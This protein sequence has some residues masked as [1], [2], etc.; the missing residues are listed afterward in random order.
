MFIIGHTVDRTGFR[1]GIGVL[2]GLGEGEVT[3]GDR[4]HILIHGTAHNSSLRSSIIGRDINRVLPLFRTFQSFRYSQDLLN[5]EFGRGG[6]HTI[7]VGEGQRLILGGGS[8]CRQGA[9]AVVLN[10]DGHGLAGC[11]RIIGHALDR[12][13]LGHGVGVGAGFGEGEVTEGDRGI[14]LVNRA[15]HRLSFRSTVL[16]FHIDGVRPFLRAFKSFRNFQDLLDREAGRSRFHA[17]G[18]GEGQRIFLGGGN[19][20]RQG[21]V[22]VVNDFDGHGLAGCLCIV[23]HALDRAG[24]GHGVGVGAGFGEGEVAEGDRG[25][26]LVNRAG[27][28]LSFRRI[29]LCFHIDGV[30]PFLRAVQA[31]RNFQDLLDREAGRGGFHTVGVGEGQRFILGGGN[32]RRQGAV[33]VVNHRDGHGLAVSFFVVGHAGDR[34]LFTYRVG[35]GAGSGEGERTEGDG[36]VILVYR[37]GH[38]FSLRGGAV[39]GHS[40]IVGPLIRTFQAFRNNQD[41]LYREAGADCTDIIGVGEGKRTIVRGA[42]RRRQGAVAVV[43]HCDR[44]GLARSVRIIGHTGDGSGLRHR[45]GVGSGFGKGEIAEGDGIRRIGDRSG[46]GRSFRRIVF[47]F[48]I[49]RVAPGRRASQ[50]CRNFKDLLHREAGRSRFDAVGVC[51]AY[52][53]FR[54]YRRN[55][56]ALAIVFNR[57]R[58]SLGG[59]CIIRY[60]VRAAALSYCIGVGSGSRE[61]DVTEAYRAAVRIRVG[62]ARHFRHRRAVSRRQCEGKLT[63]NAGR[64]KA[65]RDFQDLLHRNAGCRRLRSVGVGDGNGNR[66][67]ISG[68]DGG[69]ALGISGRDSRLVGRVFDLF[70]VCVHGQIFPGVGPIVVLIERHGVARVFAVGSQLNLNGSRTDLANI[71]GVIPDLGHGNAGRLR[72]MRIGDRTVILSRA[73]RG[74]VAVDGRLGY[75]VFNFLAIIKT[76]ETSIS[77]G[78]CTIFIVNDSGFGTRN[79][80]RERQL[81]FQLFSCQA[82]TILIII[83]VP[84][85]GDFKVG[86]LIIIS[87]SDNIAGVGILNCTCSCL[88]TRECTI[89]TCGQFSFIESKTVCQITFSKSIGCFSRQVGETKVPTILHLDGNNRATGGIIVAGITLFRSGTR[90]YCILD[91]SACFGVIN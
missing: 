86:E 68:R 46:H 82:D 20:R 18:V 54:R 75:S 64:C 36:S 49:D 19:R 41:L 40:N 17:I 6:F 33:A 16:C 38:R 23:G 89:F 70:A 65:F 77:D 73:A 29:V 26:I 42:R 21:A 28:R 27:H 11:F 30:G 12:A 24:L 31:F 25:V 52:A 34:T 58:Y 83:V 10:S 74:R 79:S 48:N 14:I 66:T 32:S 7:C 22:T 53:A 80:R 44:H 43:D 91:T 62:V 39:R 60:T 87:E 13:G 71:V 56:I 5:R 88:P 76:R 57:D 69:A 47:R 3:E 15:S 90:Y 61:G 8:R 63:G 4:R 55:Q 50:A 2:T 37:T 35:V 9:V 51:E 72:H 85:L 67:I 1:H 45:V 78:V 84:N 81:L 59:C